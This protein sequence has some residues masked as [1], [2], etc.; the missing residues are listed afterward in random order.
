M[1]RSHEIVVFCSSQRGRN[2]CGF[3]GQLP[4]F[5][6]DDGLPAMLVSKNVS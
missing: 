1:E 6:D 4:I 3:K 5:K 2:V